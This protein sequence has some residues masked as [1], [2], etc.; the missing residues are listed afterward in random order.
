MFD[1]ADRVRL[2]RQAPMLLAAAI[3]LL[4]VAGSIAISS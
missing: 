3:G 2:P 1:L 4:S